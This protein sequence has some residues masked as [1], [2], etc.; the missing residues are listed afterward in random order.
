MFFNIQSRDNFFKILDFI[1][2]K[3][4]FIKEELIYSDDSVKVV[5]DIIE[6]I[7]LNIEKFNNASLFVNLFASYINNLSEDKSLLLDSFRKKCNN[8]LLEKNYIV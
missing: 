8:K 6:F 7:N 1:E 4:D 2:E 3:E 5:N